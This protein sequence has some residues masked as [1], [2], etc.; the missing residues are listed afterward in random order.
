MENLNKY[1]F[2]LRYVTGLIYLALGFYL[3]VDPK[4]LEHII[5]SAE[6]IRILGGILIAY[7]GFRLYRTYRIQFAGKK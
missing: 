3:I 2:Y 5:E 6:H 1:L 4:S 7:G